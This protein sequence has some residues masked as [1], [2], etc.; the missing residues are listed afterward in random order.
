MGSVFRLGMEIL[1]LPALPLFLPVPDVSLLC[2]PRSFSFS[3]TMPLS[4]KPD[5]K[6]LSWFWAESR[7][8][9]RKNSK[10][11]G[12]FF[13]LIIL[14]KL[15]GDHWQQWSQVQNSLVLDLLPMT[16][17]LKEVFNIWVSEKDVILAHCI[18]AGIL[19]PLKDYVDRIFPSHYSVWQGVISILGHI[20]YF[21]I[22]SW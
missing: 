18:S 17:W 10:E 9:G 8:N 19:P 20:L 6:Q 3:F 13:I 5:K 4:I 12:S 2:S 22:S 15:S 14:L 21:S 1:F 16:I 11:R 7:N